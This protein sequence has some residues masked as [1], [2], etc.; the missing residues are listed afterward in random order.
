MK[1]RLKMASG[2]L[3]KHNKSLQI[4]VK[5]CRNRLHISDIYHPT[6]ASSTNP[7]EIA[8]LTSK[9][10]FLPPI[11]IQHCCPVVARNWAHTPAVPENRILLKPEFEWLDCS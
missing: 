11:R 5:F 2:V 6:L 7:V 8:L 4:F 9:G 3:V 10:R 1:R